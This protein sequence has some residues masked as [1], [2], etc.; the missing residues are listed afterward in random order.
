[1][2]LYVNKTA[3]NA[4]H[5]QHIILELNVKNCILALSFAKSSH[6]AT[7]HLHGNK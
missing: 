3:R 6:L 1:M 2:L 4:S 7:L 5:S